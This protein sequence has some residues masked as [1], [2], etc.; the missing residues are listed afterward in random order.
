MTATSL[1]LKKKPS[2]V[3]HPETPNPLYSCSDF[4]F[5]HLAWAPVEI[6]IESPVY[7]CPLSPI[8]LNGF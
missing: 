8:A 5:N 6:I 1:S 7:S 3:A 4:K 2:Q